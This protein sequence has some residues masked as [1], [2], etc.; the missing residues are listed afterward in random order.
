[1][2]LSASQIIYSFVMMPLTLPPSY[3]R[4]L[5][6]AAAKEPWVWKAV[7]EQAL[8]NWAGG[9]MSRLKL[10][11]GTPFAN[12]ESRTPCG[13]WHPGQRCQGGGDWLPR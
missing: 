7:Q 5:N 10:L 12:L 4:F 8:R 2:C 6:K 1:M 13:F 3:V 11:R 9:G